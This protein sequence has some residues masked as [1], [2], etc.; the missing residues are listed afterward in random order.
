MAHDVKHLFIRLLA[1]Y[2]SSGEL[3]VHVFYPFFKFDLVIYLLNF[4]KSLYI[5]NNSPLSGVCF[6]NIFYHSVAYL[7]ILFALSFAKQIFIL[8]KFSLS[9]S[10][11]MDCALGVISKHSLKYSKSSRIFPILPSSRSCIVLHYTFGQ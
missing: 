5:L 2:I 3:S 8:M 9:I 10:S 7:L 1:I 11:F 4:K 6:A